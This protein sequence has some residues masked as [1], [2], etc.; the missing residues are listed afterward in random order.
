MIDKFHIAV[1][2]FGFSVVASDAFFIGW[3]TQRGED[4][5]TMSVVVIVVV[6]KMIPC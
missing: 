2:I 6:N 4:S 1:L 3:F 5:K